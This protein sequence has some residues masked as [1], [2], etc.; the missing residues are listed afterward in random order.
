[1]ESSILLSV[2]KN[3]GISSE[4]TAFDPDLITHINAVFSI[5]HQLGI[6]PTAGFTIEDATSKWED[7]LQNSSTI[8]N[9]I[10]TYMYLK[11]RSLFDPPSTSY[12]LTAMKDLVS[13]YE[14]RL[15]Q[16]R[17]E[18]TPWSEPTMP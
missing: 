18:T 13:E 11:V 2:K 8:V 17:E 14:W 1:M 3:L 4:Y 9:L 5:I 15:N 16:L 12:H 10:K 6:G 7:F